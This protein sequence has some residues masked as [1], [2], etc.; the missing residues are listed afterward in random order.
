M[1]IQK[2]RV[3]RKEKR[4]IRV[5]ECEEEKAIKMQNGVTGWRRVTNDWR[6]KGR[7]KKK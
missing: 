1:K 6:D 3:K 2:K 5:K 7:E 4:G